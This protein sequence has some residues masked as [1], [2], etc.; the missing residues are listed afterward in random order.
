V[1]FFLCSGLDPKEN[2]KIPK[3]VNIVLIGTEALCIALH[4]AIFVRILAF[5]WK[6]KEDKYFAQFKKSFENQSLSNFSTIVVGVIF[7]VVATYLL[8]FVNNMSPNKANFYPNYLCMNMLQLYDP[9]S[10][11]AYFRISFYVQHKT[12]SKRFFFF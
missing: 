11:A 6:S 4:I 2:M 12:L 3:K 5:K 7:F 9:F 8:S 10:C 1:N